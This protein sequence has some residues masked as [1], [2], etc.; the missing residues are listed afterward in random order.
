MKPDKEKK[1]AEEAQSGEALPE[2]ALSAASGGVINIG[3][4]FLPNGMSYDPNDESY[5][6][7]DGADGKSVS[8][9]QKTG[10][11][12]QSDHFPHI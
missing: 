8:P 3:N 12:D 4:P 1:T 5:I 10:A 11:A 2:D 6:P 7:F 9:V